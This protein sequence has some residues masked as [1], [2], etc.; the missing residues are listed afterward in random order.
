MSQPINVPVYL[1]GWSVK[2]SWRSAGERKGVPLVEMYEYDTNYDLITASPDPEDDE[3]TQ[4]ETVAGF[5]LLSR[6]AEVHHDCWRLVQD[7]TALKTTEALLFFLNSSGMLMDWHPDLWLDF[8]SARFR[9]PVTAFWALQ[10]LLV[11]M[12]T[13]SK[14]TTL[15]VPPRDM[16]EEWVNKFNRGFELRLKRSRHGYVAETYT[17]GTLLALI[18]TAQVEV[19]QGKRFQVCKR[20]DCQRVFEAETRGRRKNQYCSHL[21]AHT[22]WQR[23]ARKTKVQVFDERSRFGYGSK[24]GKP[25]G[26]R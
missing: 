9:Y 13:S 1:S 26:K 18:Y 16:P 19:L 12:L 21:C 7:F 10:E 8:E 5:Q 24:T 22:A 4:R 11:R 14:A 17:E 2:A 20:A 15:S 23:R 3:K 25:K 6:K